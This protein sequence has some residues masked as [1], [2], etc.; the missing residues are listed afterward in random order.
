M[1]RVI[2]KIK[3]IENIEAVGDKVGQ[4]KLQNKDFSYNK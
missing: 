4:Y 3:H 1:N 2:E